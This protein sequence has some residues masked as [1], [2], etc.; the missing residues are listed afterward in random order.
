M[1]SLA[2]TD[3]RFLLHP[4]HYTQSILGTHCRTHPKGSATDRFH[5]SLM[6]NIEVFLTI[7]IVKHLS[8]GFENIDSLSHF[9]NVYRK[10]KYIDDL[11][12]VHILILED[13][14]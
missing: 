6:D 2:T 4:L 8:V 9:I 1:N 11:T 10:V 7:Y 12:L 13:I 14:N 5:I 3:Y